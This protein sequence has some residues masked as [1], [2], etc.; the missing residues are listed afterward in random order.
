M[1]KLLKDNQLLSL[2]RAHEVQIDG[3]KFHR[4]GGNAA[5]PSLITV[6][7][8]PNYCGSYGNKAAVVLLKD[9]EMKIK[10]YK[11]V[12]E[13]YRLDDTGTLNA[14]TWS[15]PFLADKI[16]EALVDILSR[17][18]VADELKLD[19][20]QSELE[21]ELIMKQIKSGKMLNSQ[22]KMSVGNQIMANSLNKLTVQSNIIK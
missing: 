1:K 13:P 7:S 4:W 3:Y 8:A 9:G 20:T 10:Q 15:M 5:F 18:V 19:K 17:A 12:P 16:H 14:F 2:I 11:S 6:F 22:D 21:F